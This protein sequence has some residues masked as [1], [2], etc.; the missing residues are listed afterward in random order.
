VFYLAFVYKYIA[1]LHCFI[2]VYQ[3]LKLFSGILSQGVEVIS[4]K[5][6]VYFSEYSSEFIITMVSA[7]SACAIIA[8]SVANFLLSFFTHVTVVFVTH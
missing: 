5:K 7:L 6:R 3:F 4:C 1:F 8:F 2:L